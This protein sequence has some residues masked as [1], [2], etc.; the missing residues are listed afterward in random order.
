[1][2]CSTN[3]APLTN[4]QLRLISWCIMQ[5]CLE[6]GR[7]K[8]PMWRNGPDGQKSLCNAC[9]VRQ[10]R[11]DQKE[12]VAK[13]AQTRTG[14][15]DD[16]RRALPMGSVSARRQSLNLLRGRPSHSMGSMVDF[17]HLHAASGAM[18][19]SPYSDQP[20]QQKRKPGEPG[21]HAARPKPSISRKRS[22]LWFEGDSMGMPVID[23]CCQVEPLDLIINKDLAGSLGSMT[24]VDAG[25][26]LCIRPVRVALCKTPQASWP[27]KDTGEAPFVLTVYA[28]NGRKL[29]LAR[30]AGSPLAACSFSEALAA[31]LWDSQA[32]WQLASR[33]QG[34]F[35]RFQGMLCTLLAV[36]TAA[37]CSE[38]L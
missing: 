13:E 14:S 31:F 33:D 29:A 8:T 15:P 9:G 35:D 19:V 11:R 32:G 16:A 25:T 22:C 5:A 34:N 38:M 18:P 36:H 1:M 21:W 4:L 30:P 23:M 27:G 10:Q 12:K 37:S 3:N 6:C 7:T 17:V 2:S 20:L 24:A 26:C 28:E